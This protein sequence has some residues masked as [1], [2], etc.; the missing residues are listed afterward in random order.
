MMQFDSFV[1]FCLKQI[2]GS[3][4]WVITLGHPQKGPI[5]DGDFTQ[6]S[7]TVAQERLSDA[8][9]LMFRSCS[10][11]KYESTNQPIRKA[12]MNQNEQ[13]LFQSFCIC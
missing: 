12:K 11:K 10:R 8:P 3:S 9:Q 2:M 7:A 4:L 13:I 6:G 1:L 5:G